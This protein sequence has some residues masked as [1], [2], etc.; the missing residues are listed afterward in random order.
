MAISDER[1]VQSCFGKAQ[2]GLRELKSAIVEL[3]ESHEEGLTNAEVADAL[4]IRSSYLGRQKDFLSWSLL[5]LLL[6]EHVVTRTG[7][8]YR[9]TTEHADDS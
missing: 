1:N 3:L 2:A 4:G 8:R 9:L 6:N 7:N 5:G